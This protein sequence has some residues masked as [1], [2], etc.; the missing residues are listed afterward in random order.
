MW[1]KNASGEGTHELEGRWSTSSV[2]KNGSVV[3]SLIF[4]PYSV[5][6]L[7]VHLLDCPRLLPAKRHKE[8]RMP[9]RPCFMV[10]TSPGGF[11][12]R[13]IIAC[14]CAPNLR[15]L[16]G[17]SEAGASC[18]NPERSEGPPF[19]SC[20]WCTLTMTTAE[21]HD[22]RTRARATGRIIPGGSADRPGILYNR[23]SPQNPSA[24]STS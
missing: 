19:N 21:R 1:C 20:A 22:E 7:R 3:Y 9:R 10:N 6:S 11:V 17:V 4:L 24:A 18:R 14:R 8:R 23:T 13:A 5:W 15:R 2:I 16:G 12:R